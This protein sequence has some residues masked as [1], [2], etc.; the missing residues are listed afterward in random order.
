MKT[1]TKLS[2]SIDI[3]DLIID[4]KSEEGEQSN[5]FPPTGKVDQTVEMLYYS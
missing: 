5:Y 3:V 2:R 1:K 4:W